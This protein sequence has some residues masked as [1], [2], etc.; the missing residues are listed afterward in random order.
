MS[1]KIIYTL[2]DEA[3][4]LATFSF[5][6]IVQAFTKSAGIAVETHDIS[7]AGRMLSS[8][9][10]VLEAMDLG[11]RLDHDDMELHEDGLRSYKYPESRLEAYIIRCKQQVIRQLRAAKAHL[12]RLQC[13]IRRI[14]RL[15][16]HGLAKL[17]AP[18]S[19]VKTNFLTDF[20]FPDARNDKVHA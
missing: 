18:A 12:L 16:C 17:G 10:G 6:P 13:K 2:T 20:L 5:A 8:F 7:L 1:A 4:L 19:G 14:I 3:P 11:L 9:G 15:V